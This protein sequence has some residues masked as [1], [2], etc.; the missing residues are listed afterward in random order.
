MPVSQQQVRDITLISAIPGGFF[1]I[2]FG[3]SFTQ[4]PKLRA[5]TDCDR[6]TGSRHITS[7]DCPLVPIH[8][9]HYVVITFASTD[10]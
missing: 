1:G 4:F 8:V 7:M 9:G 3:Q 5:L 10:T 6:W 2:V